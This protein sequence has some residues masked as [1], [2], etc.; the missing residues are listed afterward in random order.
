MECKEHAYVKDKKYCISCRYFG[1]SYQWLE[2]DNKNKE[3][4][5]HLKIIAVDNP[6]WHAHKYENAHPYI[7]NENNN[8]IYF[9]PNETKRNWWQKLFGLNIEEKEEKK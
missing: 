7:D 9:E 6:G 4:S 5:K 3:C 1:W 8:C 2:K